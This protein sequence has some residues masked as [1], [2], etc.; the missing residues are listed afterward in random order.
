MI[1]LVTIGFLLTLLRPLGI[2][3]TNPGV[4]ASVGLMVCA[5]FW[6]LA[7]SATDA[8]PYMLRRSDASAVAPPLMIIALLI[9]HATLS[10]LKTAQVD[11]SRLFI[12][13]AITLFLAVGA[14]FT[15]KMLLS[16]ST[17][18]LRRAAD[19]SL[20]VLTLLAI[21]AAAGAPSLAPA[22]YAKPVII[23]G[24]PSHCA[25]AYLPML[26]FR[27]A[28]ANR[29]GQVALIVIALSIAVLLQSLTMMA[30]V[31]AVAALLLRRSGLIAILLV[32]ASAGLAMDVSY[33]SD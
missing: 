30:G 31:L 33:Y 8:Q 13:S 26:L 19:V 11:F 23:F 9:V 18:A 2:S 21:A 1:R 32:T 7:A 27:T 29:K 5:P 28:I 10:N 16:V 14:H 4:S 22:S 24:E 15:A 17:T 25:L 20:L 3:G 6:I 12:S